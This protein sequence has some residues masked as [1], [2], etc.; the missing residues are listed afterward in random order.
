MVA[1]QDSFLP[2]R[3]L[4]GK[5]YQS[6]KSGLPRIPEKGDFDVPIS[7][8]VLQ[9]VALILTR[10]H[11]AYAIG[12]VDFSAQ[13]SLHTMRYGSITLKSAVK[14]PSLPSCNQEST[15]CTCRLQSRV[16]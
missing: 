5:I 15:S 10:N 7:R 12:R 3:P 13:S 11:H 1:D 16:A 9:R 8:Y 6:N 2:T 14:G 4:G